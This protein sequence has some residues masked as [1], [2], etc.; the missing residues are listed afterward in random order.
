MIQRKTKSPRRSRRRSRWKS[1]RRSRRRSRRKSPRRSRRRS[2]RKSPRRSRRRSRRKSPRRNYRNNGLKGGVVPND[3]YNNYDVWNNPNILQQPMMLRG[4]AVGPDAFRGNDIRYNYRN[5]GLKGGVVPNDIYNNY[6]AWNDVWNNPNILQQ[7]MM[8]RG[9]AVGPDAFRGNVIN[10]LRYIHYGFNANDNNRYHG[11]LRLATNAIRKSIILFN[12]NIQEY[13]IIVQQ[14]YD[15]LR[16]PPPLDALLD[17]VE[18]GLIDNNLDILDTYHFIKQKV[19]AG[20]INLY[21]GN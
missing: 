3:I 12:G 2:R 21:L 11:Y 1:P 15:H 4:H 19:M 18:D 20:D 5:N 17:E 6:D 8:L 14:E 9:H 10:A 16:A 13:N 7:P